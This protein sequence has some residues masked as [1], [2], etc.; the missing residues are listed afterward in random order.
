MNSV[1]G[2]VVKNVVEN[3][4]TISLR[5]R[6]FV[7][8]QSNTECL[9]KTVWDKLDQINAAGHDI[10]ALVR[11]AVKLWKQV[12]NMELPE[13][14]DE[15][16]MQVTEWLGDDAIRDCVLAFAEKFH[17]DPSMAEHDQ[18][19]GAQEWLRGLTTRCTALVE[20]R[21]GEVVTEATIKTVFSAVDR[22]ETSEDGGDDVADDEDPHELL[23]LMVSVYNFQDALDQNS[24]SATPRS[25]R[26][27]R[28]PRAL[29]EVQCF[30]EGRAGR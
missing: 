18:L 7:R 27:P 16:F 9:I 28:P 26:V 25:Y 23:T 4:K 14:S 15:A 3:K 29:P 19:Q 24:R 2:N 10:G 17:E 1:V 8:S 20:E 21:I 5:L 30:V 12:E 6:T 22:I 13:D 11:A